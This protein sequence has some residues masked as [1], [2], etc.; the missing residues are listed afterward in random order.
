MERW[1]CATDSNR[2]IYAPQ[3]F[4]ETFG[5]YLSEADYVA[6]VLAGPGGEFYWESWEQLENNETVKLDGV[7]YSIYHNEDIWLVPIDYDWSSHESL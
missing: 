1:I 2:G 3:A 5:D 7:E 6:D 4:V